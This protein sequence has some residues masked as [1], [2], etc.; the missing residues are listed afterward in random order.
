VTGLDLTGDLAR[1][2]RRRWLAAA[3]VLV[4]CV[5]AGVGWWWST[6]PP[7]PDEAAAA[8]AAAWDDGDPGAGPVS[9]PEAARATWEEV[10]AGMG[11]AGFAVTLDRVV[12]DPDDD[13]SAT[14][15]LEVGWTLP[16]DRA[17]TYDTVAPMTRTDD[18][19]R[20][21]FDAT[22]VHPELLPGAA[23]EV[24][25]T[26]PPR[27]DVATE[28][29]TPLVTARSVVDVGIQPS[30]VDDV[31]AT[32]AAVRD[33]LDLEL[34]GLE[35]RIDAAGPD[36]FVPLVTLREED[37]E[38]LA[39]DLQPIP[40]TVFRRGEQVLAP[41]R[42]FA[43]ATLGAAGPVTA[44]L[45]EEEPERYAP[46]DVVGLSGLQRTYDDQ[47]AG[48][49][50]LEVRAVPAEASD[51]DPT[52]LFAVDAE[53]GTPVTVSLDPDVQRAADEALADQDEFPTAAV[54]IRIS[55][56]H[57]LAVANGPAAGGLDLAL[58]GRYPPGSTFKVVTTDVLLRDGLDP[59]DEVPCPATATVDGR[60]FR[61][62]ESQEL[63]AVDFTTAFARSCNTTFV[64]LTRE[65]P[66]TALRDAATA[67]GV[68]HEPQLGVPAFTGEVPETTPGT[69]TAASAIGQGRILVSPLAV[70]DVAASAA[71]GRALPPRLVL[72]P[73]PE[74]ASEDAGDE[75]RDDL[76][77]DQGDAEMSEIASALPD[78]MRAVV[79]DGSG[80]ALADVPGGAVHAKTG[81]A[82]YGDSDPP[83]THAWVIGWQ[84]DLA[85]AVLVA[86]TPDAFGGQVAAPIAADLL[87]RLA[88]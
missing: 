23:L 29:G 84:G 11:D 8:F 39:D 83:R 14:A 42:E 61:N 33:V 59:D 43:R 86:E 63:G 46:G 87:E 66:P 78:L 48:R 34:D 15:E 4:V 76:G 36:Q 65:L 12:Q 71:R 70:A 37:Y 69:E 1:G 68:G 77:D 75:Q 27:A 53:P 6:R 72:S 44:E 5:A 18:G 55:D 60:D 17:W 32:A 54:V 82:E 21:G 49:P 80:T 58:T 31:T 88:R 64:E 41:T 19:W 40:G 24:R 45:L 3:L 79:T 30:R 26:T 9:D 47:L 20:T 16:G 22:V 2:R 25:R 28:D 7:P 56:G 57:V 67:F 81:T 38:P 74:D 85:F 50:G 51:A 10:R 73:V 52:V 62:A 35:E 13:A